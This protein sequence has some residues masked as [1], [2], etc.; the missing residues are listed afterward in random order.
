MMLAISTEHWSI[1]I[2]DSIAYA[3]EMWTAPRRSRSVRSRALQLVV[4]CILLAVMLLVVVGP[5]GAGLY[6]LG[7]ATTLASLLLGPRAAIVSLA[8]AATIIA[9]IGV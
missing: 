9:A 3:V 4:L 1:A 2:G 6:W 7:A 5:N 8:I